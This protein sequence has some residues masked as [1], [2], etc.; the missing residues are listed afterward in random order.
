MNDSSVPLWA[1]NPLHGSHKKELPSS[2]WRGAAR[3]TECQNK[4]K[5][6]SPQSTSSNTHK[7]RLTLP[8]GPFQEHLY[9]VFISSALQKKYIGHTEHEALGEY[10]R[11]EWMLK[12]LINREGPLTYYFCDG[13]IIFSWCCPWDYGIVYPTRLPRP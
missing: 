3:Y 13:K 10:T 11:S 7:Q 4:K 5:A 1:N 9:E 8:D 6:A 12:S 2:M